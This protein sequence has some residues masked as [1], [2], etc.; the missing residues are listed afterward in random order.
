MQTKVNG[1]KAP[2]SL[3]EVILVSEDEEL[4]R[5]LEG[6][7]DTMGWALKRMSD[8]ESALL[9]CKRGRPA[10][11]LIDGGLDDFDTIALFV[12]LRALRE[13]PRV[14]AYL[15][16]IDEATVGFAKMAFGI[17]ELLVKPC[18]FTTIADCLTDGSLQRRISG[19][20][21]IDAKEVEAEATEAVGG[22]A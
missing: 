11:C 10:V 8:V 18:A 15:E 20:N 17:D 6:Y 14:V 2:K 1:S 5:A 22:G 3:R 13:R 9:A 12:S 16:D 19:A 21:A 4:S 7:L